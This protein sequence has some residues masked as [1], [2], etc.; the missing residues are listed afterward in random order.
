MLVALVELADFVVGDDGAIDDDDESVD[1]DDDE[2]V[3]I[4][5]DESVDIDDDGVLLSVDILPSVLISV[6]VDAMVVPS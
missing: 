3:A 2:S 6:L 1:I 5:G 4:D